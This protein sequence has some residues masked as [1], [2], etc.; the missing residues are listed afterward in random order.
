MTR[1][2]EQRL[3]STQR[4]MLRLILGKG[5]MISNSPQDSS[6]SDSTGASESTSDLDEEEHLESW[7]DWLKRTTAEAVEAL[8]L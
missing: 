6:E 7:V 8:Q 5:R 2:L 1:E 3:R 4:R